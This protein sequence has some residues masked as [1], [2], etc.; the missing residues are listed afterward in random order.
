MTDQ[1]ALCPRKHEWLLIFDTID[2][3]NYIRFNLKLNQQCLQ[4]IADLYHSTLFETYEYNERIRIFEPESRRIN[5]LDAF[6]HNLADNYPTDQID[7]YRLDKEQIEDIAQ[8]CE[9][10]LLDEISLENLVQKLPRCPHNYEIDQQI[11]SRGS[12]WTTI[13]IPSFM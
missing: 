5:P 10:H 13:Q 11:V 8:L 1:F 6:C 12:L 2:L 7:T 3:E 9:D 4:Y